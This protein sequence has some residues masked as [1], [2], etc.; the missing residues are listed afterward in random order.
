MTQY[1]IVWSLLLNVSLFHIF[2]F[3]FNKKQS[4]ATTDLLWNLLF[5]AW[6]AREFLLTRPSAFFS[7]LWYFCSVIYSC[8]YVLTYKIEMTNK[9][10][11]G[12]QNEKY[13]PLNMKNSYL[14]PNYRKK[15]YIC[16]QQW[17]FVVLF[18]I[19]PGTLKYREG[20]WFSP[21]IHC[22]LYIAYRG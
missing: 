12:E 2:S 20:Y 14:S 11:N 22:C 10:K 5:I 8:V 17:V 13:S 3:C 6:Y 18:G 21:Y 19:Y 15:K 1:K 4:C 9:S 16:Q 7:L